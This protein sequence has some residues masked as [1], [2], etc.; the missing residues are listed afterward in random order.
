MNGGWTEDEI[1]FAEALKQLKAARVKL[2]HIK[3]SRSRESK[4]KAI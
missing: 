2:K 4:L 3:A 1:R